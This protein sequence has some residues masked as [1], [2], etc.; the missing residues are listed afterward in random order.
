MSEIRDLSVTDASNNDPAFGF[1]E[2]MN[3]S[4]VN[5]NLRRILGAIKRWYADTNGTLATTGSGNAYVLAANATVASYQAGDVYL[6]S[7]NHTN[8]GAATINV[9]ALGTKALEIDGAAVASGDIESGKYYL[10][11]YDGTA[12]QLTRLS[13]A[14]GLTSSDIGS[15]VQAEL[16]VPSQAEA[17]A[18]TATDERV[19]TAERVKQAIAA[20][21]TPVLENL[22]D[23]PA[24]RFWRRQTTTDATTS[25]SNSDD[26]ACG[27]E[28][29]TLLSDGNDVL[30]LARE[31]STV[32]SGVLYAEKWDVETANKRAGRVQFFTNDKTVSLRGEAVTFSVEARAGGLNTTVDAIR[33]ILAEWTSTADAVTSDIV[34][35]WGSEGAAPTLA[36]NWTQLA[37]AT[38]AL[39]TSFQRFSVSGTVG[40]SAN[41]LALF[42]MIEN[43]DGTVGD[44]VFVGKWDCRLGS[45]AGFTL[46]AKSDDLAACDFHYR[47]SGATVTSK[48]HLTNVAAQYNLSVEFPEPMFAAPTVTLLD[49]VGNTGKYTAITG[50]FTAEVNNIAG[51]VAAITEG[52][53]RF[54]SGT[55]SKTGVQFNWTAEAEF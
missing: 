8:T 30:D 21:A 40:A 6:F 48:V 11:I 41:N 52:G 16:A 49:K 29:F 54:D 4:D 2:D 10:A 39:T 1:P 24:L 36:T 50:D 31:L 33:L 14:P 20:L 32:P 34:S 9:D 25:P 22:C 26:T 23:N 44:L 37:T 45:D 42:A 15:T 28:R 47:E 5:D 13:Q 43:G 55:Y 19:W 27:A 12:F 17:E 18:G 38:G 46:P 53:F 35:V 7:A 51:G 3:P